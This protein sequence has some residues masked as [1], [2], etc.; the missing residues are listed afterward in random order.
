MGPTGLSKLTRCVLDTGSQSSFVTKTLIDNLKLEVVDR[1]DLLVSAFESWS[2]D[3]GPCSGVC[4]CAKSIWK[5]TTEP[6]TA[7]E[8]THAL[9]SH[10]TVPHDITIMANT[11][12][13]QLADLRKGERDLPVEVLMRGEHYWRIIKDASKMRLS[14]S[15]VLLPTKFRWIWTGNRTGIIANEIMVNHISLEHLD[16]DL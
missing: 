11:R 8:S 12:K 16:N 15:L 6:I 3:S 5:N 4:F 7:F 13:I 14:T 10:P 1:R 9:C 2:S